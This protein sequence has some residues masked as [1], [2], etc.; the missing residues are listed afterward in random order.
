MGP[1]IGRGGVCALGLPM[2][3]EV[4]DVGGTLITHSQPPPPP[5]PPPALAVLGSGESIPGEIRVILTLAMFPP[6][7]LTPQNSCLICAGGRGSSMAA[8]VMDDPPVPTSAALGFEH[9][10]PPSPTPRA[11]GRKA[12]MPPD[13]AGR[14]AFEKSLAGC[15]PCKQHTAYLAKLAP[16]TLAGQSRCCYG[17]LA[18]SA[19]PNMLLPGL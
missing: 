9:P 6:Q 5:P 19:I 17:P 4:K 13:V 11:S 14:T 12:N 15:S 18:R 3:H 1:M 8:P 16:W 7:T 2:S 10:P